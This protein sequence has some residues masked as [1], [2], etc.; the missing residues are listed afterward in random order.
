MATNHTNICTSY[1]DKNKEK[2]MEICNLYKT[3]RFEKMSLEL[4]KTYFFLQGGTSGQ[5]K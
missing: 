4:L 3:E 2:E 1:I 5:G